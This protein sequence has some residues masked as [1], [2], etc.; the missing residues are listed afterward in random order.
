MWPSGNTVTSWSNVVPAASI[1]A[2]SAVTSREP[3]R[4]DVR[5]RS[6]RGFGPSEPIGPTKP[7]SRLANEPPSRPS[8]SLRRPRMR[9]VVAQLLVAAPRAA[10]G[11]I[12]S[13]S[14]SCTDV[15]VEVEVLGPAHE[16]EPDA[17]ERRGEAEAE[18]V[19]GVLGAVADGRGDP[20]GDGDDERDDRRA[21]GPARF[22]SAIPSALLGRPRPAASRP[23]WGV[24]IQRVRAI[25][26]S[27]ASSHAARPSA[28]GPAPPKSV[29]AVV[30]SLLQV[31][32]VGGDVVDVLRR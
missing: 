18:Q 30:L 8:T 17:D 16:P 14:R 5:P 31:A 25:S 29:A 23:S 12:C 15:L 2:P 4:H 6:P 28:T 21:V 26:G 32:D 3:G 9:P 10:S 22:T 20:A 13:G 27:R 11:A 19:A 7:T 24:P 1:G